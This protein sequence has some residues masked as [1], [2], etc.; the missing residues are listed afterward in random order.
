MNM[1]DSFFNKM[2]E[3]M[4]QPL[5]NTDPEFVERFN[6]FAFDEVAAHDNM[7]APTRMMAVLA[8]LIG[9]QGIE[10]FKLLLPVALNLGVTP[11]EV[12]EIVYQS[13]GYCGIGR[14]FPFLTVT[15]EVLYAEG[16]QLPLTS[17]A[18]T[19][20]E[21]RLEKGVEAQVNIFGDGM[22]DF[23]K[24]GPEDTRH[25]NFWLAENCFGDY[26][27]RNGLNYK[28]RE[29]ITF[30]F[31]AAQGGCE[32]QLTAHAKANIRLGNDKRFL[33]NIVSQCLPYIGYPRTLNA[34]GCV[35]E[36]EKA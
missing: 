35:E 19:T 30:C 24:S 32:P 3:S 23:Y 11:I 22:K 36:A 4:K 7:D 17:Q 8:T 1:K 21:T 5:A 15:N 26:Y 27:T 33:I 2:S 9:C 34:L 13:V 29:M 25:I 6:Y 28:Q 16:I 10:T 12:K 18:T 31:L 14:V 20:V